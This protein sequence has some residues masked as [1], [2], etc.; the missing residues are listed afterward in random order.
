MIV[1]LVVIAAIIGGV[2][3]W[4]FSEQ[5]RESH[6]LH[7]DALTACT[8][9]VGQNSTAQKALAQGVGRRQECSKHYS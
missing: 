3:Y 4:R 8:E 6:Q 2:W 1:A 7:Q 5:R 9:A